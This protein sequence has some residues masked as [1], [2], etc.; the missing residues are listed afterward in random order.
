VTRLVCWLRGHQPE[1]VV[2]RVNLH[3]VTPWG[4]VAGIITA[5]LECRRCGR[6]LRGDPGPAVHPDY[7][8]QWKP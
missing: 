6:R 1:K 8:E 7:Q 5:R 3:A 2:E 4:E